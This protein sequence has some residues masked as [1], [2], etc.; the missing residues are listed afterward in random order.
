MESPP[1]EPSA[2]GAASTST[3]APSRRERLQAQ[4]SELLA[5]ADA[6]RWIWDCHLLDC[7]RE[8]QPWCG[9]LL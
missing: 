9:A 7:L 1:P 6:C 2:A 4:L 8:G 5:F 3:T